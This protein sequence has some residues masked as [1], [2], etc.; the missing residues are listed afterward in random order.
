[1][2]FRVAYVSRQMLGEDGPETYRAVHSIV[3][4]ARSKNERLGV[5]GLL[6]FV[7][8]QHFFQVLE[9]GSEAELDRLFTTICGDA[10]HADVIELGRWSDKER[11]FPYWSM[12]C[13]SLGGGSSYSQRFMPSVD[14]SRLPPEVT[15]MIAAVAA[16]SKPSSGA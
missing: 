2:I 5:T 8:P 13:A 12:G 14:L 3:C 16:M 4:G 11:W 15:E 1:M 7:E 6:V 10:R 9:C